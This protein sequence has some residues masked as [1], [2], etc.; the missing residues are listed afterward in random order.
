MGAKNFSAASHLTLGRL[1]LH[2]GKRHAKTNRSGTV[3]H[4]RT[5]QGRAPSWV[6]DSLFTA[7]R[8]VAPDPMLSSYGIDKMPGDILQSCAR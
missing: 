3:L 7:F 8:T 5:R 4:L 2:S 1:V 6:L